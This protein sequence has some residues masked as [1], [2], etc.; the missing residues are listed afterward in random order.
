[1]QYRTQS[2]RTASDCLTW[3]HRTL[4]SF[5]RGFRV[6]WTVYAS[7]NDLVRVGVRG[8]GSL[9]RDPFGQLLLSLKH[10]S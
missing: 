6:H 7:V 8:R 5:G 9:T 10:T 3:E 1:M 2:T 4:A